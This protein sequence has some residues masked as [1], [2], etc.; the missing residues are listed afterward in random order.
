MYL[1]IV[2]LLLSHIKT[3]SEKALC[4]VARVTRLGTS[5]THN[6]FFAIIYFLFI[7]L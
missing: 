2:L 1:H 3:R 4:C 6:V 5:E 7:Y